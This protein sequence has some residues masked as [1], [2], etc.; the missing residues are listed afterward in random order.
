MNATADTTIEPER[1]NRYG[2]PIAA[3]PNN[4]GTLNQEIDA[5]NRKNDAL[6]WVAFS[7]FLSGGAVVGLIIMAIMQPRMLESAVNEAVALAR[8]DTVQQIASLNAVI[9]DLKVTAQSAKQDSKIAITET[10]KALAE[11]KQKKLI[12]DSH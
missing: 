5:S 4:S 11:L 2:F 9:S 12:S 1:R 3:V 8:A 6:P 7:W 10:N